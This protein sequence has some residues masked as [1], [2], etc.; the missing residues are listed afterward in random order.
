MVLCILTEE[1]ER[2]SHMVQL[3]WSYSLPTPTP[4]CNQHRQGERWVSGSK[5]RMSF[6]YT[7]L[8]FRE[9]IFPSMHCP[10]WA[11]FRSVFPP[12]SSPHCSN[13]KE[14]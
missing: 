8:F 5:L 6:P 14:K 12:Q 7:A 10:G 9:Q 2:L 4:N 3:L 11:G 13:S 1:L